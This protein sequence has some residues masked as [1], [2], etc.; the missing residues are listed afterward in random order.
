MMR[1]AL[2]ELKLWGL[3]REFELSEMTS[4]VAASKVR[5]RPRRGAAGCA[6]GRAPVGQPRVGLCSAAQQVWMRKELRHTLALTLPPPAGAPHRAHQGVAQRHE[7]GAACGQPAGVDGATR[8]F[9]G[10][11]S[12]SPVCARRAVTPPS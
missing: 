9:S 5:Q 12:C 11:G 10:P 2:A 1:K 6:K 8:P 7:R 3:Q 4:Q